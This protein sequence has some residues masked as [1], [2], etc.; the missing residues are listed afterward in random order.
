ME[1][2][3]TLSALLICAAG[4]AQNPREIEEPALTIGLGERFAWTTKFAAGAEVVFDTL[5]DNDDDVLELEEDGNAC[6]LKG[7]ALG[8]TKVLAVLGNT[9]YYRTVTV[10]AKTGAKPNGGG[11]ETG[12]AFTGKYEYNPPKDHYYIHTGSIIYAKIGSEQIEK[13]LDK[14][15]DIEYW[16]YYNLASR[17]CKQY[18]EKDGFD[19]GKVDNEQLDPD[20][21]E[22]RENLALL[23]TFADSEFWN[24]LKT[25]P[26]SSLS[27]FYV[28]N[29]TVCGVNCWV[30]DT[31]GYGGITMKY[32][33]DPSTGCC[34]KYEGRGNG[35]AVK[36]TMQ[37]KTYNLNYRVWSNDMKDSTLK[38]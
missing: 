2:I 32:W 18:L 8:T 23:D 12:P 35:G 31:D 36:N 21:W 16:M 33:V 5:D 26:A 38:L 13:C 4:F 14:R 34:L 25:D 11:E 19:H 17:E 27:E 30:F 15:G 22:A 7:V 29:E 9:L 1:K 3:L 6:V 10:V 37:V 20:E 28:G 24:S